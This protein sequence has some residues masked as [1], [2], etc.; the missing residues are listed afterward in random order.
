MRIIEQLYAFKTVEYFGH[1]LIVPNWTKYLACEENGL[2]VAYEYKPICCLDDGWCG[3]AN[4]MRD[5]AIYA[6][7]AAGVKVK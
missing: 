4:E 2:V 3:G 6:I 1:N 7:H 5:S